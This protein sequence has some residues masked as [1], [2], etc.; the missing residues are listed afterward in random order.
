M[1][2]RLELL[3]HRCDSATNK[4]I[5]SAEIEAGESCCFTK[6]NVAL[7]RGTVYSLSTTCGPCRLCSDGT[8]MALIPHK[9]FP[10][11]KCSTVTWDWVQLG[12]L[13]QVPMRATLTADILHEYILHTQDSRLVF[14]RLQREIRKKK[15]K[16]KWILCAQSGGNP[17]LIPMGAIVAS[18]VLISFLLRKFVKITGNLILSVNLC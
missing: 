15:V 3:D 5:V 11:D 4:S 1:C 9:L 14:Y 16:L 17:S 8:A 2:R 18:C 13:F 12:G 7:C 6:I 10:S